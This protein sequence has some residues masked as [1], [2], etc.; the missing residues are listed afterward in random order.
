MRDIGK[1]IRQLR[2]RAGL[3]QE[4]LA[5]R[6]F[7]TRQTVSNYENGHT[8]P[9]LDM[10]CSIAGVLDADVNHI[11]YGIP[12]PPDKKGMLRHLIFGAAA[13]AALIAALCILSPIAADYAMLRYL[14]SPL[15]LV[16][17]FLAPAAAFVSGWTLA[18]FAL[19][20]GLTP[21]QARWCRIVRLVLLAV[22][23]LYLLETLPYA[24]WHVWCD[25]QAISV[26]IVASTFP[27]LPVYT[28]LLFA[29]IKFTRS[30]LGSFPV[31]LLCGAAL[32]FFSFPKSK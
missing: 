23:L 10:L 3:T 16:R 8:R 18:Q 20:R 11:L 27:A 22:L 1:N 21:P 15:D 4:E 17:F 7:V 24:L 25:R 5:E 9:D 29:L 2:E 30:F 6:L 19:Y 26:G 13:S 32:R 31:F 12:A 28:H 14:V